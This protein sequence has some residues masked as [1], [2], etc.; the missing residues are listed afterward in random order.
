MQWE[1]SGHPP[2]QPDQPNQPWPSVG[3]YAQ[4]NHPHCIYPLFHFS[5]SHKILGGHFENALIYILFF[6]YC[7]VKYSHKL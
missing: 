7:N 1:G 3:D 5:E 4:P 6:Y 2:S